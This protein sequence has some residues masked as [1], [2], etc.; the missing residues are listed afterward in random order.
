MSSKSLPKNHSW[1]ISNIII[2]CI[3]CIVGTTLLNNLR[4]SQSYYPNIYCFA[5][6]VCDTE[7]WNKA[8]I[9]DKKHFCVYSKLC[10][11]NKFHRTESMRNWLSLN[12]PRNFALLWNSVF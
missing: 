4:I 2:S 10:G 6:E 3:T 1:S 9:I 8:Q 11:K 5:T 7:L 12:W